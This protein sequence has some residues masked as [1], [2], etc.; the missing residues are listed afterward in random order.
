MINKLVVLIFSLFLMSCKSGQ[1]Q[2]KKEINVL[3]I[4]NSLTY[5]HEMPQTLQSMVNEAHLNINIHQSTFPGMQ[6]D[7]HLNHIIVSKSENG[8]SVR[9]KE[10]DEFTNTEIKIKEQKWDIVIMQ[11]GGAT[12]LDNRK[13]VIN[14]TISEIKNLVN[15]PNCKFVLFKTWISLEDYFKQDTVNTIALLNNA[16]TELAIQ[17]N[18]IQSN[19]GNKF[20]EITT[21]YPSIT[22]YEDNYHPNENGS[23]LNACIFYEILTNSKASDLKYTGDIEP[24]TAQLLKE[25]AH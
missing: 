10:K 1:T 12:V 5:F 15:N 7:G 4:G 9:N 17:N 6:L 18:V 21:T 23:F 22:L 14:E 19:N 16:Y 24:E 8:I 20:Y 25:I 2:S 3:F 13:I 11:T